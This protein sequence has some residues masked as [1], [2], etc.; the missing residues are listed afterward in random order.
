MT[1]ITTSTFTIREMLVPRSLGDADAADFL[2]HVALNNAICVADTGLHDFARTA[3]EMLPY[4]SDNTDEV[5]RTFL[6]HAG[7]ELVGACTVNYATAEPTS[8]EI[9]LMVLPEHWGHG[10]EQ[11]LL[12]RGEEVARQVGRNVLQAWTMHRPDATGEM[13]VPATGWG[14]ISA[15]PHARLLKENGF[16]LEQAERNSAFDLQGPMEGIRRTLK[17]ELDFAGPDYRLLQWTAPTP[18]ELREGYAWAMSR[19]S[20][21][22]PSG[23][24]EVDEEVWDA[25][26]VQRREA[27][28][29][30]GG[31]TLSVTAVEHVPTGT[32]A[33]VNELV[34][35]TD[36]TGVSHQ[37][38]TLVLKEHR[39]HHLGM[40][41]KC[42]NILRM[43][44][45]APESPRI[46]TF[47]AEEN[48]PMLD[49][50]EALGFVPRSYAAAWQK[51][52]N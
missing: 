4:M 26:R 18:P 34:I 52:L 44:E 24:L 36:P 33:A 11:A 31:Q 5:Y 46:T 37:Y 47:N 45:I 49:I 19:M 39:G 27:R 13:L 9:D 17:D 41:V 50:N 25:D 35:G 42:A 40:L 48:R 30:G 22:A 51:R 10:V 8:V 43:R 3:D 29:V 21:D 23:G 1:A 32:V 12:S 7:E 28:I 16:A 20:T 6:A 38:I 2:A 14:R 15:T